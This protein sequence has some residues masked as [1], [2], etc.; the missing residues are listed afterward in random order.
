MKK[1]IVLLLALAV[2]G[3]AVFAQDATFAGYVS[4]GLKIVNND[5]G[6]K[7]NV[8]GD[9]WGA[10]GTSAYLEGTIS[11]EKSGF[12]VVLFGNTDSGFAVDTAYGWISPFAGMKIIGGNYY[13]GAFDGVDDDSNDYFSSEGVFATYSISGFTAGAGVNAAVKAQEDVNYVFGLAYLMD[14][15]VSLRFSAITNDVELEKMSVSASLLAVPGLTVKAGY[16]ADAMSTT[17]NN[18]ADLT[19]GYKISDALAAQVVAYDYF[20]KEYLTITPRVTYTASPELAVYGQVAILTE[21][22]APLVN[23]ATIKPR[24][25]LTYTPD[26]VGKFYVQGEYDTE[27]EQTTVLLQYVYSF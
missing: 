3:G 23:Y 1:A 25:R 27:A 10:D 4:T 16:L 5:T 24:V 22:A 26:A 19:V 20:E 18:W 11:G 7:T 2:L 21:G 14:E 17:A 9:D 13:G 6:T 8:Y 15:V 12:D